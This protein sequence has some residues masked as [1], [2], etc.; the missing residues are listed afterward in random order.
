MIEYRLLTKP[1]VMQWRREH[2]FEVQDS[3]A[4]TSRKHIV[5]RGVQGDTA[6]PVLGL[7]RCVQEVD[8]DAVVAICAF[9][10][11]RLIGRLSIV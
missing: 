3:R 7:S 5:R 2:G 8:D 6:S 4:N 10:D 1:Q 9:D 11:D